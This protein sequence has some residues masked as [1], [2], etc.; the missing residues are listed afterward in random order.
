MQLVIE[1]LEV[2]VAGTD[3]LVEVQERVR[4][5]AVVTLCGLVWLLWWWCG[6]C[7]CIGVAIFVMVAVLR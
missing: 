1:A 3:L 5:T 2:V 7:G 4:K 6:C